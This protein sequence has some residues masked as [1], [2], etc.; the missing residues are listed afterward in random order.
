MI[1]GEV[2]AI[3]AVFKLLLPNNIPPFQL[4]FLYFCF[5]KFCDHSRIYDM[6]AK[7]NQNRDRI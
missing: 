5:V 7:L 4:E 3:D 1:L 6:A 2:V